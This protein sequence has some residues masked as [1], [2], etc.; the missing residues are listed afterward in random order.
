[1]SYQIWGKR[2]RRQ[3]DTRPGRAGTCI[4]TVPAVTASRRSRSAKRIAV[5]ARRQGSGAPARTARAHQRTTGSANE[6]GHLDEELFPGL[7]GVRTPPRTTYPRHYRIETS[8]RRRRN[9]G[10]Q[11]PKNAPSPPGVRTPHRRPAGE[12]STATTRLPRAPFGR[13]DETCRPELRRTRSRQTPI[14]PPV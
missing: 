5:E 2:P 13:S 12:R 9:Q 1:M 3:S 7:D 11:A 4:R 8:C 14:W 10:P 6:I